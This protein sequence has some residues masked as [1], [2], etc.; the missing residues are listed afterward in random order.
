MARTSFFL[1]E[2]LALY[3]ITGGDGKVWFSSALFL[4][5]VQCFRKIPLILFISSVYCMTKTSLSCCLVLTFLLRASFLSLNGMSLMWPMIWLCLYPLCL[6][7][8]I[9][10]SVVESKLVSFELVLRY[11]FV[12]PLAIA[13]MVVGGVIGCGVDIEL[14]I[15]SFN[16]GFEVKYVCGFESFSSVQG[17]V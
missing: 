13:L 17:D 15:G 3:A 2:G 1:R 9:N 14:F 12:S 7:Y 4:I 6:S 11:R 8:C 5:N 10:L 16:V